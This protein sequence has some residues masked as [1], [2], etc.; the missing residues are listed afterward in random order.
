VDM[1]V[2]NSDGGAIFLYTLQMLTDD[3]L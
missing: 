2:A 1:G 3:V